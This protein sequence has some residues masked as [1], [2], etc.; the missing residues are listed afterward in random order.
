MKKSLLLQ[1]IWN[2]IRHSK[3]V[4]IGWLISGIVGSLVA[5]FMTA[6]DKS[7]INR[8]N[9]I[10]I[11]A[12][13]LCW[14]L[15]V[16]GIILVKNLIKYMHNTFVDSVYGKVIA[17]LTQLNLQLK[18]LVRGENIDDDRLMKVLKKVCNELK[19]FFDNK[20]SAK[21][22]VSIKV[23]LSKD[24]EITSWKFRN[25]CRDDKNTCRDTEEYL[26]TEHTV[27]GNTPYQHVVNQLI[28]HSTKV[29][30]INNNIPEAKDYLNTSKINEE[31]VLPYKSE[32]VYPIMPLK[33]GETDSVMCGFL[34]VDC[35]KIEKFDEKR[36][37]VPVIE[38]IIDKLYE[39][40]IRI[41]DTPKNE[42]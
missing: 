13:I 3:L 10:L 38:S 12:I 36:Y 18:E 28:R 41:I 23:T 25:L 22:G 27:V 20:T 17:S 2:D 32:I 34:C 31:T 35:D 42:N 26:R 16:L 40:L 19:Q 8:D 4:K 9:V 21:C 11:A 6:D 14:Y 15:F 29:A 30:Y 24:K 5:W 33:R 37:D 7:A 39:L 1:N